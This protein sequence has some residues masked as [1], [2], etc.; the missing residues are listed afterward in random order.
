MASS[1]AEKDLEVLVG[2]NVTMSQECVLEAENIINI[3]NCI[4]CIADR[5]RATF[6]Q[7]LSMSTVK[8][9]ENH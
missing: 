4:K 8:H 1:F 2:T 9:N 3:C 7:H 6:L 5:G